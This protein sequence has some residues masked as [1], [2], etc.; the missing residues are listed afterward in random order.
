MPSGTGRTRVRVNRRLFTELA[1]SP[2]M[3]ALLTERAEAGKAA[4]AAIAPE[5]SGPTWGRAKRAGDYKKSLDTTLE[6][7]DFGYYS[8]FGANVPYALQVEFGTGKKVKDSGPRRD[9]RG[10][11]RRLLRRPQRGHS[12]K[13]R[14]LG[15]ALSALRARRSR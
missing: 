5:Y 10:K 3:A 15:R 13:H 11:F 7:T 2:E 12:P 14:P 1:S 9:K 8:T 4:A 6:R